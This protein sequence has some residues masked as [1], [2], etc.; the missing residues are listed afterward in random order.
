[1]IQTCRI[2]L[3]IS[4]EALQDETSNIC[5]YKK[6]YRIVFLWISIHPLNICITQVMVNAVVTGV[7][8]TMTTCMTLLPQT[9]GQINMP[10]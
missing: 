2:I 10:C 8:L 9:E 1:M 6:S 3:C 7:H 5:F 4:G